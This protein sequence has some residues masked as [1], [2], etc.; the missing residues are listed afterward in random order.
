MYAIRSYYG[1]GARRRGLQ[2]ASVAQRDIG[3]R[4]GRPAQ[5]VQ[6]LDPQSRADQRDLLD[7]GARTPKQARRLFV[8]QQH[9]V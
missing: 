2:E 3:Q 4:P 6:Q 9:V 8:R 7:L 5:H 1:I